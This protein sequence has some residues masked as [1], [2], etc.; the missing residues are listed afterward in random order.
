MPVCWMPP[1]PI[2]LSIDASCT[3]R[4]TCRALVPPRLVEGPLAPRCSWLSAS[5]KLARS[6]LKPTVLTF[7]MSLAAMSSIVW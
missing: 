7:A 5:L 2:T 4:P 3:P 1:A 6:P